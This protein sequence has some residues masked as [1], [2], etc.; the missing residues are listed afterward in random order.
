MPAVERVELDGTRVTRASLQ[1]RVIRLAVRVRN[2][3]CPA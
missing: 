3:Q 1:E 2:V